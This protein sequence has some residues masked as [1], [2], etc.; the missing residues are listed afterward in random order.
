MAVMYGSI[1]AHG[2]W[3]VDMTY[4]GV[5]RRLGGPIGGGLVVIVNHVINGLM[6]G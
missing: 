6:D 1:D 3:N 4:R 5:E 2:S